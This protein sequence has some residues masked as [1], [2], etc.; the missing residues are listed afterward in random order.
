MQSPECF[1]FSTFQKMSS[2]NPIWKLAQWDVTEGPVTSKAVPV[3]AVFDTSYTAEPV[4]F[5]S[6]FQDAHCPI[7]PLVP[8]ASPHSSHICSH[9]EQTKRHWL[10]FQTPVHVSVPAEIFLTSQ[11]NKHHDSR[12]AEE[13]PVSMCRL[14]LTPLLSFF[15]SLSQWPRCSILV[16][17]LRL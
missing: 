12:K 10:H 9:M 4:F 3:K 16:L 14:T 7:S 5:T 6:L 17:K 8:H 1:D 2:H 15:L 13:T 11:R